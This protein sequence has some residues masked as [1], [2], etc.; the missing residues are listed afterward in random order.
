MIDRHHDVLTYLSRK[1][2]KK[3]L[4]YKNIETKL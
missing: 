4:G 3:T 2:S 1:T